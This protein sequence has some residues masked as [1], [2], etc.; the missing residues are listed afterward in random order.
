MRLVRMGSTQMLPGFVRQRLRDR[1]RLRPSLQREG[2]A[3]AQGAAHIDGQIKPAAP[4]LHHVLGGVGVSHDGVEFAARLAGLGHAQHAVGKAQ[5]VA[6]EHLVFAQARNTQV[7][8]H[9]AGRQALVKQAHAVLG[10]LLGL[11][12]LYFILPIVTALI[13]RERAVNEFL[14][15][16]G[17]T[18]GWVPMP[19]LVR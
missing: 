18:P 17:I 14:L 3:A 12:A 8:A 13:Y 4:A 5:T 11:F 2:L 7:F 6:D 9:K 1:H 15:A 16:G 19:K 10:A